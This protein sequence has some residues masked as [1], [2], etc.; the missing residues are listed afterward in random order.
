MRSKTILSA[1]LLTI[2]QAHA[3]VKVVCGG[4]SPAI[5]D[6]VEWE[7]KIAGG[8][9]DFDGK[10]F[11]VLETK[12]FFVLTG[13]HSQI[14]I[15]KPKESYVILGP[16]GTRGPAIEWSRKVPGEGCEISN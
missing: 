16:K 10:H 5:N 3:D 4:Y 1:I 13:P 8:D 6:H 7:L 9:A 14:R 15:N 12:K 11:K 2:S